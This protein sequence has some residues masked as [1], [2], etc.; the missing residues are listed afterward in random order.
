[1][2]KARLFF[3]VILAALG[4]A[5]APCGGTIQEGTKAPDFTA[6]G[7]DGQDISLT[8]LLGERQTVVVVFYRGFF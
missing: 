4:L 7:A 8:G 1:M 2:N 3:L 5:V 6:R